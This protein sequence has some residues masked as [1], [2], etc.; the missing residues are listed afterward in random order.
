MKLGKLNSSITAASSALCDTNL[1][2]CVT[3]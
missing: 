3:A 1:R 2:Y